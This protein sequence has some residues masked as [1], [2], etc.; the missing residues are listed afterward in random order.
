MLNYQ[1][2]FIDPLMPSLRDPSRIKVIYKSL[3]PYY[4][5]LVAY[6]FEE[7]NPNYHTEVPE[8]ASGIRIKTCFRR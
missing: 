1:E 8:P 7:V 2:E 5:A 3:T 6:T 4:S